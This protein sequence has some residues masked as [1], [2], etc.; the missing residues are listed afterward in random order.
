MKQ[1]PITR[2]PNGAEWTGQ[3]GDRY[4]ITGTDAS[5]RRFRLVHDSWAWASGVN[6][7]SGSRWLVRDG[8]RYLISRVSA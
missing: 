1:S 6:L 8:K 2:T 5:G 3:A 7:Y 4:L